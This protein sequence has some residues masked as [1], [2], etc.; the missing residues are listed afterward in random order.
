MPTIVLTVGA[1]Y[2]PEIADLPKISR[3]KDTT[4]A[5]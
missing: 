4:R 3:S 1:P 5:F 2:R